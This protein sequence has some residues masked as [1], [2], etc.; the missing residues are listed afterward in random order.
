MVM[1]ASDSPYEKFLLSGYG[2]SHYYAAKELPH[3]IFL[4]TWMGVTRDEPTSNLT[5][6]LVLAGNLNFT[7]AINGSTSKSR[8]VSR[9]R[10]M[11]KD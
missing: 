10:R 2:A 11:I 8:T 4:P 1:Y 7:T 6:H 3:G 5:N 9:V